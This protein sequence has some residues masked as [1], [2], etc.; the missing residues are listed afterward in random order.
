MHLAD[1]QVVVEAELDNGLAALRLRREIADL[2]GHQATVRVLAG[3]RYLLRVQT[4]VAV[5]ARATG[6][7]DPA[8]CPVRGLPARV[9][10]AGS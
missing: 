8:G 5:L 2:Y 4:R 6:L 1:G 7:I 3:P 10:T 9:V